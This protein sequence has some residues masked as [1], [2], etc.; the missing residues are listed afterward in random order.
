M[1]YNKRARLLLVVH[2]RRPATRTAVEYNDEMVV[3]LDTTMGEEW[4][5][6]HD[7]L[8]CLGAI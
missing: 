8:Q 4:V 3:Y 1:L 2:P 6:I 7:V 5:G